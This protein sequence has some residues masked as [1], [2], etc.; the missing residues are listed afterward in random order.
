MKVRLIVPFSLR[1]LNLLVRGSSACASRTALSQH[2][3]VWDLTGRDLLIRRS[4]HIV[5]DRPSRSVRWA[6]I[7]QPSTRDRRCPAPWLQSWLQSRVVLR[8]FALVLDNRQVPWSTVG[9]WGAVRDRNSGAVRWGW[10][11]GSIHRRTG[12]RHRRAGFLCQVGDLLRNG[13]RLPLAGSCGST[14]R[15]LRRIRAKLSWVR[16]F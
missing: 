2:G 4:R 12:L 15:H 9:W 5:Q 16:L 13:L 1:V 10:D 7:P 8:C 3:R 6:D 11:T 14:I